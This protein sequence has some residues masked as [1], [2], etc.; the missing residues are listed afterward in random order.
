MQGSDC[1][2]KMLFCEY[3]T[4]SESCI[5][6]GETM[7]KTFITELNHEQVDVQ[8]SSYPDHVVYFNAKI[9]W[10]LNIVETQRQ[11]D[12]STFI[13]RIQVYSGEDARAADKMLIVQNDFL[14]IL[15]DESSDYTVIVTI[16]RDYDSFVSTINIMPKFVTINLT[17]KLIEVTING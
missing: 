2:R 17:G 1:R 3:A 10:G 11:L 4:L 5:K 8:G 15:N 9:H 7:N 14:D 16:K 13:D 12:I 6:L